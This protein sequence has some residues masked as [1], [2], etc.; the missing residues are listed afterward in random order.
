VSAEKDGSLPSIWRRVV[1]AGGG[2]PA[3][4]LFTWGC[5]TVV[6]LL[7]TDRPA[8]VV[9]TVE[10]GLP[11]WTSALPCG[12]V[13]ERA[14]E[15][16]HPQFDELTARVVGSAPG[17]SL[18]LV[19][20]LTGR[21]ERI[22]LNIAPRADRQH[23]RPMIGLSP[24]L[25]TR[26]VSKRLYRHM[27]GPVV[28]K[29]AADFAEP[30]FEFDDTIV[31]AT[32]PDN[33]DRLIPLREDPRNPG[34][35]D[36]FDWTYRLRRLAGK[37]MMV[38]VR[39]A[40]GQ[41]DEIGLP[42]AF[43]LTLGV[44]MRM[45]SLAYLRDGSAGVAAKLKPAD[46]E[47]GVDGD[48]IV[49]VAFDEPGG[50]TTILTGDTLDPMRLPYQLRQ[51][52]WRMVKAGKG[53]ERFV[54]VRVLR[55]RGRAGDQGEVSVRLRWD[56]F[57]ERQIETTSNRDAPLSISELGLSYYVTT[58]VA[59]AEPRLA[60]AQDI[61]LQEGEQI[62]AIRFSNREPKITIDPASWVW[63]F[64]KLQVADTKEV[65]L[66]IVRNGERRSITARLSEDHTWP[67]DDRG[68][69]LSVD[70]RH[71]QADGIPD[72]AA[73]GGL[74]LLSTLR[75]IGNQTWSILTGRISGDAVGGPMLMGRVGYRVAEY[76]LAMF[77]HF[78]GLLS[79]AFALQNL[80]PIPILDGG[81]AILLTVE[82]V[83]G[84]PLPSRV[85]TISYLVGAAVLSGCICLNLL[86]ELLRGAT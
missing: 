10:V 9:G 76:D 60:G 26:L 83:Y 42:P 5:F 72:A 29:T 59:G 15:M 73:R 13:I 79:I 8:A 31:G 47:K 34:H 38:Q 61:G 19:L 1:M 33:P 86:G 51:W 27:A 84:K 4:V 81:E 44:R 35:T 41:V 49:A 57:W 23:G 46:V 12:A 78:I 71:I 69:I 20:A 67:R 77:I 52:S 22:R 74:Q 54:S 16:D 75:S 58:L 3:S 18:P 11:A 55:E 80:L 28:P 48:L 53:D 68:L 63:V 36:Y 65:E 62:D 50:S 45:G 39:R 2:I 70:S 25:S 40:S 14:G 21:D 85:R 82:T 6:W 24:P 7:G 17:Q 32:D 66:D 30:A 43:H 64:A 56:A 37:P